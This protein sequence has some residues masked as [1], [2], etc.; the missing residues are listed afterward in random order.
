VFPVAAIAGAGWLVLFVILLMAPP[1]PGPHEGGGPGEGGG[2]RQWDGLGAWGDPGGGQA[3]GPPT[4]GD[5]PPAV[6]SLLAGRLDK[7]GF[8]ATLVD[9]AARGWFEI[10]AHAGS[11]DSV[12]G[13]LPRSQ[14][15]PGGW[16]PA[17]PFAPAMCVVTARTPN[18]SLTPFERRV[19]AHVALRAGARGE[20]PAPALSD[21]FGGGEDDFMSA[22]RGEVDAEA[23]LRGLTRPWLSARRIALLCLTLLVPVVLVLVAGAVTHEHAALFYAAGLYVVGCLVA[24]G[25]G[26]SRRNS[27]AGRAA[28]DRWRSAV[29]AAPGGAAGLA[30]SGGAAGLAAFGGAAGLAAFGGAAGLAAFGGGGRQVAYAAALG[31]GSAALAVFSPT[32]SGGFGGVVPPGGSR[33]RGSGNVAW[34]SYRG[35]WQQIE[36]ESSTWSWPK[37]CAFAAAIAF[38]P[39]AFF[40][41]VL[42]LAFNGMGAFAGELV[43]LAVA[44][45]VAGSLVWLARRKMFPSFAEFDGQVVRQWLVKDSE[46]PDE[47]HV[48]ID[49]GTRDKAWDLSIGSEPYR[50]LPPGTFVHARVNLRNREEVTVEPVEPPAVARPLEQVAADQER[51][52]TGA[53][54]TRPGWSR[55][56]RRPRSW[57]ARSTASTWTGCP[58]GP[59]SGSR[60]GRR[61]LCCGS[62]CGTRAGPGRRRRPRGP[63]PASPTATCWTRA[64]CSTSRR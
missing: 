24:I 9:L 32:G 48:A 40:A 13:R 41:A 31:R 34:S 42:W 21:G 3:P 22:F 43:G 12:G 58:A 27:A 17:G 6:V 61:G 46:G 64:P 29:A 52:A 33:A 19:V 11:A 63:S 5:E 7:T 37:G 28:L 39:I 57:A 44:G 23:R 50:R 15:S 20:V 25:V 53:C 2:R 38:G 56:P 59:W 45:A 1:S 51:A 26:T 8:G 54:P 55:R 14:Q 35:G 49:D 47:Y 16:G 4:P 10:R 30:A 36:I 60:P 18:G 62:R